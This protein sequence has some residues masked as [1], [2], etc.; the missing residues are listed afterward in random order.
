MVRPP[1]LSGTSSHIVA[2]HVNLETEMICLAF[3]VSLFIPRSNFLHVVNTYS[4]GPTAL[5]LALKHPSPQLG[6]NPRTLGPMESTLTIDTYT[7]ASIDT[8]MDRQTGTYT[9]GLTDRR[10][11]KHIYV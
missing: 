8:N 7:D 1:E 11:D 4:M 5:L 6:L 2:N 9:D 3:E 10:T